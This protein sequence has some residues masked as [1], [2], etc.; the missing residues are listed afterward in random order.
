MN[1]FS[2]WYQVLASIITVAGGLLLVWWQTN[3]SSE[4]TQ[5]LLRDFS[6]AVRNSADLREAVLR[7]LEGRWAYELEWDEYFNQETGEEDSSKL[8]VSEGTADIRWDG[9]SYNILLG[10]EN[11][12]DKTGDLYSVGVSIGTLEGGMEG[13]PEVG[14]SVFMRYAH[15]LSTGKKIQNG[16][17]VDY[18]R[19]PEK[20]YTYKITDI[21]L[22]DDGSVSQIKAF[23]EVSISRGIV[24]FT[25]MK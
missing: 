9:L 4:E 25:K 1:K 6:L 18:S 10:Y 5:E 20:T 21:I 19:V 23:F 11:R 16:E 15:R 13:I 14:D 3:K 2:E 24:T 17:T 8:F 22:E 12:D 7:P